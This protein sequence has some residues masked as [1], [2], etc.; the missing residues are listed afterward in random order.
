MTLLPG[1][2]AEGVMSAAVPGER[3]SRRP[4]VYVGAGTAGCCRAPSEM[5]ALGRSACGDANT[6]ARALRA[7]HRGC[8]CGCWL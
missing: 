2:N 5:S 3:D 4:G 8:G 6:G 1:G 7:D